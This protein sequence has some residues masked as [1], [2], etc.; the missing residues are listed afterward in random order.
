MRK[1]LVLACTIACG[2]SPLVGVPLIGTTTNVA[3][4]SAATV[5]LRTT[6]PKITVRGESHRIW[7]RVTYLTNYIR[8]IPRVDII[9]NTV[10]ELGAGICYQQ[11]DGAWADSKAELAIAPDGGAEALQLPHK[12]HFSPDLRTVGAVKMTLPD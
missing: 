1:S 7:E 11:Q 10:T 9:T 2:T 8:H 4:K 3:D 6:E 12:L 5:P